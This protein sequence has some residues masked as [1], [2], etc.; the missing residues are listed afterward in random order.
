M[1]NKIDKQI[2][3]KIDN[4]VNKQINNKINSNDKFEHKM[5]NEIIFD[6]TSDILY[7]QVGK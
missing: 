6:N 2:K 7:S 3:R 1:E 5:L 4:K